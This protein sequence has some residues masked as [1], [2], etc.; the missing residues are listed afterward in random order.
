MAHGYIYDSTGRVIKSR[1][2][3]SLSFERF[4]YNDNQTIVTNALG[5]QTKYDF[6][7]VNEQ[8]KI[9][10]VNGIA[11]SNCVESNVSYEYDAQGYMSSKTDELGIKTLYSRD[12]LGR[13][14][15]RVEAFNTDR[16]KIIDTV[17]NDEFN[18]PASISDPL[19][20]IVFKYNDQGLLFSRKIIKT[21]PVAVNGPQPE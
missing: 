18:L 13:E 5:R 17:W 14:I 15:R 21:R 10:S 8:F 7:K 2:G 12:S 1:L 19:K 11:T 16:Q 20:T 9:K 3:N 4:S 6:I